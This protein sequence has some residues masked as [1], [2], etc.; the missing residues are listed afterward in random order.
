METTARPGLIHASAAFRDLT[1]DEPWEPTGGVTVKGKGNMETYT[2]KPRTKKSIQ[3][4][5]QTTPDLVSRD[6]AVHESQGAWGTCVCVRVC[7]RVCTVGRAPCH[8]LAISSLT[9]IDKHVCVCVFVCTCA[10]SI[11]PIARVREKFPSSLLWSSAGRK[12]HGWDTRE[13]SYRPGR[14]SYPIYASCVFTCPCMQMALGRGHP[15]LSF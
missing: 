3:G 13:E 10:K 4:F 15:W 12:L 11:E 8:P 9:F 1:P 14:K 7:V 5:I 6:L 2:L